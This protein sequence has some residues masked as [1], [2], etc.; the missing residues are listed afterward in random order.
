MLLDRK[1][2]FHGKGAIRDE[3]TGSVFYG[4]FD[5]GHIDGVGLLCFENG[6][7]FPAVFD[8]QRRDFNVHDALRGDSAALHKMLRPHAVVQ[9]DNAPQ[10]RD[11]AAEQEVA[12]E[13]IERGSATADDGDDGDG[14]TVDDD[15]ESEH[16]KNVER[17]RRVRV[18]GHE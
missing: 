10:K 13:H 6:K 4:H 2:L 8:R 5:R 17:L 1:F 3:S 16:R 12:A 9:N 11:V 7:V 18:K 15:K 14:D